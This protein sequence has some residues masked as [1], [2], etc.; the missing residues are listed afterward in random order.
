[1]KSLKTFDVRKPRGPVKSCRREEENSPNHN[2]AMRE[3]AKWLFL[4]RH[5]ALGNTSRNSATKIACLL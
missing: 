3:M 2:G 5:R 4:N 1:M